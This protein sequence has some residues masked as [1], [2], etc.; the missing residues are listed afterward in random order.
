MAGGRTSLWLPFGGSGM[1]V[2]ACA[3]LW[4]VGC[5]FTVPSDFG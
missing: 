3:A 1:S 4:L 2:H 5:E